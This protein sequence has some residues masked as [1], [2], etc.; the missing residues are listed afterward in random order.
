[1]VSMH[2]TNTMDIIELFFFLSCNGALVA[3]TS[4]PVDTVKFSKSDKKAI[5][6]GDCCFIR[7]QFFKGFL[8]VHREEIKRELAGTFYIGLC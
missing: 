3:Q 2:F 7:V 5:L 1:M 8:R 6:Q 4:L